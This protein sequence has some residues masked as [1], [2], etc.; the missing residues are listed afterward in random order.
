MLLL[1]ILSQLDG[2]KIARR[3]SSGIDKETRRARKLLEDYNIVSSH[4]LPSLS[5]LNLQDVLS[6][7]DIF[8]TQYI[9]ST[10]CRLPFTMK[11]DITE[12]YLLMQRSKE[13]QQ[14]LTVEMRNALD[15]WNSC[16]Q[17]LQEGID[18][19]KSK[20]DLYSRGAASTLQ[21]HLWT[22]DYLRSRAKAAFQILVTDD[23]S[24]P[25]AEAT[26]H[27]SDFSDTESDTDSDTMYSD[28]N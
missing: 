8:W 9:P 12:A 26:F 20:T 17:S 11:K 21:Q 19:M 25:T 7:D 18:S 5:P 4:I 1:R 2:Q 28:S 14:L 3:L 27:D 6:P 24:S 15:F 13:E 23:D 22:I 16:A 10:S